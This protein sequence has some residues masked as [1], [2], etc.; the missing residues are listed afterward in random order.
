MGVVGGR[1]KSSWVLV[2]IQLRE[3]LAI[4]RAPVCSTGASS[5]SLRLSV[6]LP[7]SPSLQPHAGPFRCAPRG[8]RTA[9][10]TVQLRSLLS[11]V[12]ECSGQL[13]SHSRL[14]GVPNGVP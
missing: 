8:V 5:L 10:P 1:T 9:L 12:G 6:F 11:R 2:S 14:S 7:P 4:L 13:G 3:F